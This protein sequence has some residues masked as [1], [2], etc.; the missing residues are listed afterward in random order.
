MR[1]FVAFLLALCAALPAAAVNLDV[2]QVAA[3]AI[4]CKFQSSCKLVANDSVA[5]FTLP[6]SS[7]K[8][9]LQSR[10]SAK[11]QAGTAA[12]GLTPYLYRLDLTQLVGIV[13]IPCVTKLQLNF[14]PVAQADYDGNGDKDQVFVITQGGLGNVKPSS[15]VQVGNQ[16][17]FN[18]NTPVCAG[19]APGKGDTS[20]FIGLASSTTPKNVTAKITTSSGGIISL[21]ARSPMP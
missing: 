2:V 18:F 17:T 1:G 12:A 7:G 11:G 5:N 19:G 3:P 13:N 20:Y 16:I 6:G 4:N 15:V 10:T 9:F 8:A 14:G 21:A